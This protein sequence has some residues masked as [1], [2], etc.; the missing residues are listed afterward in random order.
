[1]QKNASNPYESQV[2]FACLFNATPFH[3]VTAHLEPDAIIAIYAISKPNIVFCDGCDYAL[4][5]RATRDWQPT[6]V[7]LDNHVT[8][9]LKIEDILTRSSG[10]EMDYR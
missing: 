3:N 4:I 10:N 5:K 9:V 1:M 8:N 7:T 2:L 6:I